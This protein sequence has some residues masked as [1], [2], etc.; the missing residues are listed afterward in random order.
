[1]R[2]EPSTRTYELQLGPT[3]LT[4]T[5]RVD[6]IAEALEKR[7]AGFI[8]EPTDSPP[9]KRRPR[10]HCRLLL[11]RKPFSTMGDPYDTDVTIDH[12]KM[13]LQSAVLDGEI[14]LDRG[15]GTI[16]VHCNPRF[17]PDTYLEN[18]FRQIVQ[19]LA[20][21]HEAF[22][23]HAAAIA[24]PDRDEVHVFSG[25]SGSGKTTISSLLRR[26]GGRVLSD[27]L[28][29]IDCS[30][31]RP[32]LSATPFFGT[33]RE[34]IPVP[35]LT[36]KIDALHFLRKSSR[37]NVYAIANE[38]TALAMTMTNVPFAEPFDH[39]HRE[40]LFECVA[41]LVSS[42]PVRQLAFR[43]DLS[44]LAAIGWGDLAVPSPRIG[45]V[46]PSPNPTSGDRD[47]GR[48]LN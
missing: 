19:V 28:V 7:Y 36:G 37:S 42:T 38:A 30:G 17:G 43:K 9:S 5:T 20:V 16:S 2:E 25:K 22:L 1:M 11:T 29:M 21:E 3:S 45:R 12:S 47:R 24:H 18:A 32:I 33:L 46:P 14:D 40:L 44:L 31:S 26:R 6:C 41:Q 48:S 35:G 8:V 4:L 13:T 27:D 39:H 23:L 10:S 15:Q 34:A